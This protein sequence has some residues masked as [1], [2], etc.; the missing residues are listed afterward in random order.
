MGRR[1]RSYQQNQA[2]LRPRLIE[3]KVKESIRQNHKG[4]KDDH[5]PKIVFD[6]LLRVKY[7]NIFISWGNRPRDSCPPYICSWPSY[8]SRLSPNPSSEFCVRVHSAVCALRRHHCSPKSR[9][10]PPC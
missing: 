8:T 1:I 9:P 6:H 7:L 2:T 5:T 10:G 4:R 3:V